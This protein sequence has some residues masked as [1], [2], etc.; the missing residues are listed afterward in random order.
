MSQLIKKSGAADMWG[1]WWHHLVQLICGVADNNLWSSWWQYLVQHGIRNYTWLV[2]HGNLNQIY[3]VQIFMLSGHAARL[4]SAASYS[5]I[6]KQLLTW[7]INI[8]FVNTSEA[9]FLFPRLEIKGFK[10]LLLKN[11]V[12]NDVDVYRL[13]HKVVLVRH[14]HLNVFLSSYFFA[15]NIFRLKLGSK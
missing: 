9:G 12:M 15:A 5:T 1:N 10:I 7:T 6:I 14:W 3:L 13:T 2:Y 4:F 8:N 11:K